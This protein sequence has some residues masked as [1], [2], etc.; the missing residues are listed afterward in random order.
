MPDPIILAVGAVNQEK[1][2]LWAFSV[3]VKLSIIF[4]NLRFK[5]FSLP[6]ALFSSTNL[7]IIKERLPVGNIF[8]S[9]LS[10]FNPSFSSFDL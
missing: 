10:L 7:G 6:G 9:Q 3:I 5:L 4:G 2:Q 8:S 1:A